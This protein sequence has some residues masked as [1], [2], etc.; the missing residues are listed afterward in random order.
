[1]SKHDNQ[2]D[3]GND[4]PRNHGPS[5]G[6]APAGPPPAL[7]RRRLLGTATAAAAATLAAGGPERRAGAAAATAPAGK[8]P[9]AL[10]IGLASYS[11]RKL[12]LDKVIQ[13]CQAAAIKRISL[14][15]VH[16]PLSDPPEKLKAALARLGDA[17]ITV[18]SG[19][20][21]YIPSAKN[22]KLSLAEIEARA[23]RVFDYAKLCE[24][25]LIVAAPIPEALD[26]IEKLAREY[27]IL[28][29][30][31]NHGPDDKLYPAPK[32]VLA[33]IKTRDKRI[34]VC[35]DVGH[36]VR[37]GSDPVKAA[38]E[39]GP[40]LLDVH[41]KDLKDKGEKAAGVEVGRGVVDVVALL[42][43][44]HKMKFAGHVALESEIDADDPVPAIRESMGYMRGVAATLAT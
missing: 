4:N 2:A 24:L 20:V 41:M 6:P 1:M 9:Y 38:L 14:K 42:R 10:K 3:D 39:C 37:A 7:S 44:L 40:R 13:V 30:I 12:P 11:L 34:G 8:A 43:T 33:H 18:A 15:D 26:A 29:A 31:H 25:P 17:G 35:M 36:T 32:D 19:G 27:D 21:I 22:E 28:V 5:A 23:R 16:L